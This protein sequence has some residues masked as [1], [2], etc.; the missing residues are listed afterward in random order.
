MLPDGHFDPYLKHSEKSVNAA[1]EWFEK[2][3]NKSQK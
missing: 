1:I 3:L 2:Y